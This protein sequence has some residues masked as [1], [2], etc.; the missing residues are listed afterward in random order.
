MGFDGR[1]VL[2]SV[3]EL[4][5]IIRQE[6]FEA[7]ST[8]VKPEFDSSKEVYTLNE[9]ANFMSLSTSTIRNFVRRGKL[10]KMKIPVKG[11][12]FSREEL[13]KFNKSYR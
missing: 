7:N 6:Y 4:R 5:T 10:E 2:V 1:F 3:E 8:L 13:M 11:M 9:A 12:R